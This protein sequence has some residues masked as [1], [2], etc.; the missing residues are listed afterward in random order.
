MSIQDKFPDFGLSRRII[1]MDGEQRLA[2]DDEITN[3]MMDDDADSVVNRIAFFGP[4]CAERHRR[5]AYDAGVDLGQVPAARGFYQLDE[6]RLR[7]FIGIVHVGHV[8]ALGQDQRAEF[9][10]RRPIVQGAFRQ[11]AT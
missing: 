7:Q 8:P 4:T 6:P 1:G 2:L 11:S 5:L 9:L 10:V 3:F